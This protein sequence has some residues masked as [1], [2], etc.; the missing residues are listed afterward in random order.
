MV[1]SE[2]A[3]ECFSRISSFLN[4]QITYLLKRETSA[5]IS[6]PAKTIRRS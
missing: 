5:F 2:I 3:L 4:D 6:V 1:F